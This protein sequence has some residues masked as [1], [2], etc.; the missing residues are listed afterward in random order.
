[1]KVLERQPAGAPSATGAPVVETI[2]LIPVSI[3][4]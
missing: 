4:A 1:M 2:R 3:L